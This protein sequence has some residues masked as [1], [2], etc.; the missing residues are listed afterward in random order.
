MTT[1]RTSLY[2]I[3]VKLENADNDFLLVHGYTGAMD[4][5]TEN[6][7]SFLRK[8]AKK[9]K[10]GNYPIEEETFKTLTERGYLT[11][12]SPVEE[13]EV[14]YEMADIFHKKDSMIKSFLFLVAYDCNFRC[15]YCYE[16]TI[17]H[18]GKA[19]SKKVFT[20][21]AVDRAYETMLE[22]EPDRKQHY[23]TIILYGGEPLLVENK[24][25][26]EYMVERGVKEKYIFQAVTNGYDLEHFA[27][28]LGPNKIEYL[29]IT[30]DGPPEKHNA[31]RTHYLHG[32]SF[33]KIMTNIKLALDL[34]TKVNI[35]INTDLNNLEDIKTVNELFKSLG[36][37]DYKNFY[38]HSA[39]IHGDSNDNISCN[40]IMSTPEE[41]LKA[42]KSSKTPTFEVEDKG[43]Y[44]PD[45]QYIDFNKEEDRYQ[46]DLKELVF[47]YDGDK[48][49][50]LHDEIDRIQL[51]NRSK[52]IDSYYE[53][54]KENP[55]SA[56]MISCQDFGLRETILKVLDKGNLMPF[57]ATFCGAQ[58]GMLIFDPCGDLY[59][60][61]ETVGMDKH[62]IGTYKEKL[63]FF[64]EEMAHWYGRNISKTPACSKCKYAFFCGGGC[65]AHALAEGRG[66]NSSY[67]DGFPRTFQKVVPRAYIEH[68]Q[69]TK[70][71]KEQNKEVV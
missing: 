52:Y 14:V 1:Y 51:L 38:A 30:V 3:F 11:D 64:E 8:G 16:N 26:V 19:W 32:N 4:L 70:Q 2:T 22:V 47:H 21:D 28:L 13:K 59:T 48:E 10:N 34:G 49:N 12:K 7:A 36:F 31:R 41:S 61:W 6:V 40:V 27:H 45:S 42:V 15:P 50:P 20:K 18:D 9:D 23:N 37:F 44:D 62:K 29:Q 68:I 35:R 17:S 33:E 5:V 71:N 39:L 67:C 55:A 54:V 66:Y 58:T 69:N 25:I 57:K 46:E 65:Q 56:H 43:F 63:E 53:D 24:D 60:C